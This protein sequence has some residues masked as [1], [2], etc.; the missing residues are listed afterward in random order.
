M[1]GVSD[2]FERILGRG[3]ILAEGSVYELLRRDPAIEFDPEIAHA[4]LIYDDRFRERL[5]AVH[6]GYIA[7]AREHGLPLVALADTWRASAARIA[8]SA[9]AGRAVNQDNVRFMRELREQAGNGAPIV[10]TGLTGPR[11]DAY[12][13]S[14]AP[15]REEAARIHSTQVEALA[16]GGADVLFGATLPSVE[17]A[18]GIADVMSKT[19][20]PYLLS[21]V[22]RPD[23]RTLD[24]AL[25]AD[26]I[27]A[28]DDDQTRRPA[29]YSVNCV[30]PSV[31]ASAMSV[32]ES[33]SPDLVKRVIWFQ[34]NT[35]D[36]SPEE[37]DGS[38]VL[39]TGD[40]R[41][42]AAELSEAGTKF[43]TRV[44]GGCCG[45]DVSHIRELAARL[46]Q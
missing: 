34:A 12:R 43:G 13:P 46:A 3:P 25:L 26:A 32:L 24:G 23:G 16:E 11:G 8:R 35:S 36:K 6:M 40:A 37:I 44:L 18:R 39:V 45:S 10:I 7:I 33:T 30:H 21:F 17:E 38:E 41:S 31:F 29:G 2:L 5:A 19:G 14:E 42:Y 27:R 4:G 1:R 20:V 9:F 15:D 28:I 22:V